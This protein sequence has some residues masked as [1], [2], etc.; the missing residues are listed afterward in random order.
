MIGFFDLNLKLKNGM[1]SRRILVRICWCENSL[2]C[3]S[4]DARIDFTNIRN[5]DFGHI[6]YRGIAFPILDYIKKFISLTCKKISHILIVYFNKAEFKVYS[7]NIVSFVMNE[8]ILL[9]EKMIKCLIADPGVFWRRMARNNGVRFLSKY[10]VG[11]ARTCDTI[12][13]NGT[14]IALEHFL[15]ISF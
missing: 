2:T 3:S 4:Y 6:R 8:L 9:C 10:S 7:F 15:N 1:R 12:C 5:G 14:I 13:Q 11:F